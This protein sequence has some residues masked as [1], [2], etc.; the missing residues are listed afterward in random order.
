M[1]RMNGFMDEWEKT[2]ALVNPPI[3]KSIH[4]KIQTKFYIYG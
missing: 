1:K 2:G 3:Q 4:P